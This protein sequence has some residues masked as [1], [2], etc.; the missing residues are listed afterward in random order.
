MFEGTREALSEQLSAHSSDAAAIAAAV[1][2][3][4]VALGVYTTA[5]GPLGH[6][7]NVGLG[8]ALG[9]GRF[10]VPI[11]CFAT[12]A[13]LLVRRGDEPGERHGLRVGLG[14][15][16]VVVS[17]TGLW[18]LAAG[19]PTSQNGLKAI[20]HAGGVL[21]ALT[22][23]SVAA[24]AGVVGASIILAA[25]TA[26]GL[27][28]VT[29]LTFRAIVPAVATGV[30]WVVAETRALFDLSHDGEELDEDELDLAAEEAA[31]FD[32]PAM[33][34]EPAP[35]A[36]KTVLY[37]V[38]NDDAYFAPDEIDLAPDEEL[39]EADED[40]G[41][42]DEE[43]GEG[44]YEDEDEEYEE[45]EDGEYE[46]V[47]ED[48]ADAEDDEEAG[49]AGQGA[50]DLGPGYKRTDWKLPAASLLKRGTGKQVD[51]RLIDAGGEVLEATLQEFG[52]DAR[53]IGRA[54]G[55]TVSRYELELA[56]GVKV[57]K[58][59]NLAKEIAYA[60]ASHD[61][62]ILAP[63]PGRSAIGVEV[64]NKVRPIITLGDILASEEAHTATHPLQVGLGRDISGRSVMANLSTFPHVLIAGQTGA[65]KSSCINSIVTT[66]LMRTTP[67]QVRLILVDPK[68]VE[69]GQYNN[70]PHLLTE[71]VVNPKKAANALDWAVRE[72]EMRYDLLAEVGV[73]DITGYN[74]APLL[75]LER[76]SHR[77]RSAPPA[78]GRHPRLGQSL[79]WPLC[80]RFG[81]AGRGNY[82]GGHA[83]SCE[84]SLAG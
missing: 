43:D 47:A 71:V 82:A 31:E 73:R 14:A 65:G 10:F 41:R 40:D 49:E 18:H 4:L 8:A 19:Q 70:V 55:P 36:R 7:L 26:L 22:G 12:T 9:R 80:W 52:V 75:S 81:K 67:D 23:S 38:M 28:L 42:R 62:R 63:I 11:A 77:Y 68:R 50:L 66:L 20:E 69:L 57:S 64:P 39:D 13:A 78:Q 60:M 32:E 16:L 48:D 1:A 6:A 37:D 79:Y 61:V 21:G 51:E 29:G 35:R 56:P 44:E 15:T 74:A 5:A 83:D 24:L 17:V 72:M 53:L 46:E 27:L 30:R 33:A 2:G 25:L 3:V 34:P 45:E 59:T 54:I 76:C 58:V 84:L